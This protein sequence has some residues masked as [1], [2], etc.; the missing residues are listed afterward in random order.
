MTSVLSGCNISFEEREYK[1]VTHFKNI[2]IKQKA[3]LNRRRPKKG[4]T[5]QDL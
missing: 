5:D 3:N 4:C 2:S 1:Y